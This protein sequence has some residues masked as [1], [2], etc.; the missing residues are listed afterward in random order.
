MMYIITEEQLNKIT[1]ALEQLN[2][3]NPSTGFSSMVL[4]NDIKHQQEK[5]NKI[6][7]E[8]PNA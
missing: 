5:L 7:G 4:L 8:N 1:T 2:K 3:L 6:E